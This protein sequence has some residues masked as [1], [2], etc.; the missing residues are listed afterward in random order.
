MA[1]TKINMHLHECDKYGNSIVSLNVVNK[2]REILQYYEL[3]TYRHITV[4][5]LVDQFAAFDAKTTTMGFI[6]EYREYL[7]NMIEADEQK[8]LE[9]YVVEQAKKL[10]EMLRSMVEKPQVFLKELLLYKD[11]KRYELFSGF[12]MSDA[13]LEEYN[14]NPQAM[15]IAILGE[16]IFDALEFTPNM[17]LWGAEFPQMYDY[18]NDIFQL[19]QKAYDM[20]AQEISNLPSDACNE[21]HPQFFCWWNLTN[22]LGILEERINNFRN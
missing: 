12:P 17:Y 5:Y 21:E 10:V 22:T 16:K 11:M 19:A 14:K 18:F 9:I 13:E 8:F 4:D 6:G 7:G 3:M 15:A 1:D 20:L 2:E